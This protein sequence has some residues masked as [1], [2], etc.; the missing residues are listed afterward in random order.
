MSKRLTRQEAPRE[1]KWQPEKIYPTWKD[2]EAEYEQSLADIP[3]LEAYKGRLKEGPVVLLEYV[4]EINRQVR[5]LARL[6]MFAQFALSVDGQDPAPRPYMGQAMG[7]QGRFAAATAFAEPELLEIGEPILAWANQT[8]GLEPYHFYFE[9]LLKQK[10]HLRS[11]EIEEIMG[12]LAEPFG[13]TQRT[14][15]DL[16]NIDIKFADAVDSQGN[17]QPVSQGL[18]M[19]NATSL[20]REQ[21]RTAWESFCDGYTGVINTLASNY[22]AEVKQQVFEMRVRGY[23][24]VL[25]M[26]LKPFHV[27]LEVFHNL[28]ATFKEN[29]PTWHKYWEVKRRAL[30][31]DTIHPYDI[32]A[33]IGTEKPVVPFTKAVDLICEGVAPLGEE[34]VN[35][36]RRGC[37]EEHWVDWAPNL[38]KRQGAFSMP[39]KDTPPWIMMSYGDLVESMSTLSHE[40]GHSM[41]S[42]YTDLSQPEIYSGFGLS[43]TLA[44]TASNFNQAMVRAHLREKMKDDAAFQMALLEEAM[45]NYH[46]YLFQMLNLARFELEVFTRAE[47]DKPLSTDILLEIMKGIYAEG[48]GDTMTDDPDRTATTWAQFG[49]LYIPFYTFQYAVGISAADALSQEVRAGKPG[50]AE[51]YLKFIR[52]GS[53]NYTMELFK[54]AGIDMTSPEPVRK[55]FGVLASMVDQLEKLVG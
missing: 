49:H 28:I 37:L 55:A 8:P 5:R 23:Q 16:T 3:K 36:L 29:L 14:A 47:Q 12:M 20:D 42:Y 43:M 13:Q 44:E 27:P 48:Y 19:V 46:R 15:S 2:W 4:N 24:S 38:G 40:L 34:Y 39:N 30:K 11:A 33:P 51:N 31:L 22:I 54:L 6:I 25:E 53:S 52:S 26:R 9:S 35:I 10:E 32:W 7:L 1:S 45:S 18:M 41:H 21:R 50:A 17:P